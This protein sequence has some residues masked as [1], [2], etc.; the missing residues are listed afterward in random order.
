MTQMTQICANKNFKKIKNM[1]KFLLHRPISVLMT[2]LACIIIGIIT[3]TTLPVSLLPDIAI[4]RIT[5]Q[6]TGDNMSAREL[7]NTV[8]RHIRRQLMQTGRLRDMR[9]ETRDGAAIVHLVF[10]HGTDTDLA[11]IEVNEKI[12]AAMSGLPRDFRRPRVIKASAADLPVF[13]LNLTLRGDEPFDVTDEQRFLDLSDFADNIVRRRIEQLPE[14]AMADMTGLMFR[15]LQIVPDMNVLESV[16]FTLN[17]IESV[18]AANNVDFGSMMVRDGHYEYNIRFSSVLRTP[19]DVGNIF[20]RRGDRIFQLRDLATIEVVRQAESGMSVINGKRAVTLS[21]IQQSDETMANLRRS[22]NATIADLERNHPEIE[23][24]VSRNQTELLDYSIT[25]LQEN[26]LL[27]FILVFIVAILFLGDAKS[28]VVIGISMLTSLITSFVFLYLFGQSLNIITLAGLI[29]ALG[30]M[31]DSS[32][33]VT[34]IISQ[35]R[36]QGYS[37]EESCIKGTNDVITP[38]LSSTLTTIAVFVPLVFMSGIAGAIFFSQALAVSIG[39][40]VSYLTGIILLPVLYKLIYGM[41]LKENKVS[42]F[43]NRTQRAADSWLFRWYD[44]GFEFV[45]RHKTASFLF[46]ILAIPFCVFMF[47]VMPKSAMPHLEYTETVVMVDWN[48]N[49]HVDENKRRVFRLMQSVETIAVEHAGYVGFQQYLLNRES[50]LSP[51]EAQLYF[52]TERAAETIELQHLIV[53]W[54]RAY[55]PQAVV[56]FSPP[57]NIFEK[58]FDTAE[59]DVVVQLFPANREEVPSPE[60][61]RQIRQK[62]NLATGQESEDIAFEQQI[63][64]TVDRERLLLHNVN[65]HEVHRLLRT[66]FRDNEINMLRSYQQ[67]LPISLAGTQQTV[68]QILRETVLQTRG[69]DGRVMSIPLQSLVNIGRGEDIKTIVAGRD[70][71]FIPLNFH[72]VQ[73]P[74]A[75]IAQVDGIIRENRSWEAFFSGGFFSNRQMLSELM[76]ILLISILLMYFI[77]AS[78]FESFLQPLIVLLEIPTCIGIALLSLWITGHSLNLMSA[79]GL[80]VTSGIIINDSILK[81]DMMNRLRKSGMPLMEAIHTAG[82]QRLRAIIMTSLTTV[83]AM[84]PLLF[85]ADLGS[86]LQKPLAVAMIG[87][88][89]IGVL[90]SLFMLPVVYWAIYRR[91]SKVQSSKVQRD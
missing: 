21:I 78:Q 65:Y 64:I 37:L 17:D 53:D 67:Y 14:V 32:I 39:L 35:Y 57:E 82:V 52:R 3:Y 73:N 31:I 74:E 16:G 43:F 51:S 85:S 91:S 6:I 61:I 83:C 9:S 75:L 66:A 18:L 44:K 45:F 77:L 69:F 2:F 12:D 25:N 62:V 86:E 56:S 33:I 90:V 50:T 36:M 42:R 4:P 15:H 60:A 5:V 58:I 27:G 13:F 54:L 1:I 40:L 41:K 84:A 68:E 8:V 26:L 63:M 24:T 30:M 49:I 38:I 48:E 19:E 23:F 79:I 72:N 28:P 89:A 70:G 71:E 88:M 7:E 87:T 81:L 20:L 11:F 80:I 22:L 34:D 76:V 47:R 59:P 29:L 10:D 55:Y 46:L